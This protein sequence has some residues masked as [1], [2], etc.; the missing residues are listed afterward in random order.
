MATDGDINVHLEPFVKWGRIH[1][2]YFNNED[3]Y[4]SYFLVS[5]QVTCLLPLV[6][7]HHKFKLYYS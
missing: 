3:F 1:L 6:P 5:S 7:R 2:A 4:A